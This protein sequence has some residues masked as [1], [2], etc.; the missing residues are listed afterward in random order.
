MD[1]DIEAIVKKV[2][3]LEFKLSELE[4]MHMPHAIQTN[5]EIIRKEVQQYLATSNEIA[6]L[7]KGKLSA[8]EE[9][10]AM[11]KHSRGNDDFI[12]KLKDKNLPIE[13]YHPKDFPF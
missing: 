13:V 3:F 2:D 12:K 5:A 11:R 4:K 6:P 7:W 10:K 8:V 9:V 1:I